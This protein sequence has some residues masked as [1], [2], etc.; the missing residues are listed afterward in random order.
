MKKKGPPVFNEK[1]CDKLEKYIGKGE[2]K[3][4]YLEFEKETSG[5]FKQLKILVEENNCEEI[6]SILHTMKGTSGSLG[7]D[8]LAEK[9]RVLESRLKEWKKKLKDDLKKELLQD[10]P[11]RIKQL[12]ESYRRFQQD[13][14]NYL[15]FI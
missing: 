13:Y 2:I 10:L 9:S 15:N 4:L 1:V 11:E 5:F 14:K 6:L 8:D 12:E 7:A 3:G